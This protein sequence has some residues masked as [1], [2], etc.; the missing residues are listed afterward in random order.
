MNWKTAAKLAVGTVL[1]LLLSSALLRVVG[2]VQTIRD[3]RIT[4]LEDASRARPRQTC[5]EKCFCDAGAG[6]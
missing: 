2:Q 5:A 1:A 3:N 6:K 4:V